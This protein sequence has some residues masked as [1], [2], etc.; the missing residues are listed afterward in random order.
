MRAPSPRTMAG[1]GASLYADMRVKCIQR[2][3]RAE[4]DS[5]SVSYVVAL[6]SVLGWIGVVV[7]RTPS[8]GGGALARAPVVGLLHEL[9]IEERLGP[10]HAGDRADAAVHEVEQVLVVL[11]DDLGQQVERAGGHHDVVDFADRGELVGN[12][13][14][15]AAHRD[16]DHRLPGEPDLHRV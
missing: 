14:H 10:G 6:L 5:A 16:G 8:V 15:V 13:L 1:T 4:A 11:D 3:S 9:E 12:L 7:T 2:C